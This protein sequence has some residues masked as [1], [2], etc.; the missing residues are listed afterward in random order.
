MEDNTQS[1][2]LLFL[3]RDLS[4]TETE[5]SGTFVEMFL[6]Y[7]YSLFYHFL[8]SFITLSSGSAVCPFMFL[9]ISYLYSS[10]NSGTFSQGHLYLRDTSIQGS[11]K[12]SPEKRPHKIF[13]SFTSVE[14]TPL[15]RGKR[16]VFW[17]PKPWFDIC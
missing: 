12:I 14:E 4:S 13:A 10:K 11:Q 17:V 9:H 16:H 3:I 5:I 7:Y 2:F 8:Y 15:F 1:D 6:F